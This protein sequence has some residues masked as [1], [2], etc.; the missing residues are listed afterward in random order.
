[1]KFYI[2]FDSTL[3]DT[4]K[5]TSSMLEAIIKKSCELNKEINY[6][7]LF[8]D[9]TTT[10]CREKIYNIYKLCEYV[11][12]KYSVD[13]QILIVSVNEVIKNG[14][15]YIYS[16]V[17]NYLSN[18][19]NSGVEMILL[20]YTSNENLEYQK[21]KVENSGITKYFDD[22][23]YT[24]NNKYSLDIDYSDSVFIDDNPKEIIGLCDKNTLQIIRIKRP[25]AK[26][27]YVQ[28]DKSDVIEISSLNE[29]KD[30]KINK[31]KKAKVVKFYF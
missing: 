14:K 12:Y 26:Y 7:T 9:C 5:L 6:E 31:Y 29:L 25:D 23:I 20:T 3:Y 10:F 1:M 30:L 19:K 22:I 18:L 15:K 17:I 4:K 8:F 27:S 2:D 13:A 24:T 21:L 11:G 16:D 28:I